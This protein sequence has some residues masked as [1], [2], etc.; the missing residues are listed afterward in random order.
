MFCCICVGLVTVLFY[1]LQKFCNDFFSLHVS[2]S[3]QISPSKST[4]TVAEGS[5][6][7]VNCSSP[8]AVRWASEPDMRHLNQGSV[9]A[10]G[11]NIST[12][13]FEHVTKADEALY[14]CTDGN[15]E[16]SFQLKVFNGKC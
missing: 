5:Y 16:Q 13:T 7:Q 9:T 15:T 3:V 8:H 10:N 4:F 2:G 6:L 1:C 11:D 12:L 14:R